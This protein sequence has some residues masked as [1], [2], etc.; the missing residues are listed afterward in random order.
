MPG[1]LRYKSAI[2]TNVYPFH[3]HEYLI[4]ASISPALLASSQLMKWYLHLALWYPL[5][6]SNHHEL[7]ERER[8]REGG[9]RERERG[10]EGRD[11]AKYFDL[12]ELRW[13]DRRLSD[14]APSHTGWCMRAD[15]HIVL[16]SP[17]NSRKSLQHVRNMI[18]VLFCNWE[19]WDR[20][21]YLATL[22]FCN[23]WT[24][25]DNFHVYLITSFLVHTVL[26]MKSE[27]KIPGLTRH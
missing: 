17:H 3:K 20:I 14:I 12:P 25:G 8:E 6:F 10:G 4:L 13:S 5:L 16:E 21:A 24:W 9:E 18:Y 27:S 22:C 2:Y 19:H 7:V 26:Y 11:E 1:A 15:Y 23:V